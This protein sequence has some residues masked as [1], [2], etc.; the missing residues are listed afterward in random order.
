M[1]RPCIAFLLALFLLPA[2][3]ACEG[4]SLLD[5]IGPDGDADWYCFSGNQSWVYLVTVDA[6]T[7]QIRLTNTFRPTALFGP[8]AHFILSN[9]FQKRSATAF[10]QTARGWR[11][12]FDLR[13]S[14]TTNVAATVVAVPE[15]LDLPWL[16]MPFVKNLGQ[17]VTLTQT[18]SNYPLAP[19][20]NPVTVEA[21]IS[22]DSVLEATGLDLELAGE[23]IEHCLQLRLTSRLD[24]RT[25]TASGPWSTGDIFQYEERESLFWLAPGRGIIRF[26]NYSSAKDPW[27]RYEQKRSQGE[28]VPEP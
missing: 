28:L 7:N 16:E 23:R 12:H 3:G 15:R 10:Y 14:M 1:P 21:V 4:E 5:L 9:S 18:L 17:H 11:Q 19:D 22:C 27:N 25:L 2:F 20:F 26:D 8:E 6:A 24:L 13:Q